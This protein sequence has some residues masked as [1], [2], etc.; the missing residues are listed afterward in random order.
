[1]NGKQEYTTRRPAKL[2]I[3]RL[4]SMVCRLVAV[5]RT[6]RSTACAAERDTRCQLSYINLTRFVGCASVRVTTRF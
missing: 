2:R 4:V 6:W 3:A 1:M 5:A